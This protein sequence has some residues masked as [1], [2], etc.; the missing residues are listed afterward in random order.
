[1]VSVGSAQMACE[2]ETAFSVDIVI[3][4]RRLRGPRRD[5]LRL[6]PH[7]TYGHHPPTAIVEFTRFRQSA[8]QAHH[9]I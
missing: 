9:S 3:L 1:M 2:Y 7:R 5:A 8:V 4:E 6:R